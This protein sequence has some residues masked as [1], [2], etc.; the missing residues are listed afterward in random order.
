MSMSISPLVH[1][2]VIRETMTK[3]A[4]RHLHVV[5]DGK[6]DMFTR[7][8]SWVTPLMSLLSKYTA[9]ATTLVIVFYLTG[10]LA[11]RKIDASYNRRK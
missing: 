3:P 9:D 2:D 1:E 5:T 10:A 8:H 4:K 11:F 6:G 7:G